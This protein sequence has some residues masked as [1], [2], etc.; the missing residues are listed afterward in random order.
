[1]LLGFALVPGWQPAYAEDHTGP[2]LEQ[3]RAILEKAPL[4]DGHNDLPMLIRDEFGGAITG[5]SPA[6]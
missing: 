2:Y 3:A 6:T 4:V 1:M 5:S